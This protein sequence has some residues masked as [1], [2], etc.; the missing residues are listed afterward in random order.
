[1]HITSGWL[2]SCEEYERSPNR[3]TNN[4]ESQCIDPKTLLGEYLIPL[5]FRE[6]GGTGEGLF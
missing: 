2:R 5:R 3:I 1:M 4:E 6:V